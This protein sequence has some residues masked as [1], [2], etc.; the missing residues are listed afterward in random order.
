[1]VALQRGAQ[2]MDDVYA[3]Y[4]SKEQRS[5]DH[6]KRRVKLH[7]A[8]F[9]ANRWIV[10]ITTADVRAYT[11]HRQAEGAALASI[12]NE[13]SVLKRAFKLA[14][15][16]NRVPK[17]PYIPMP[18]TSNARQGFFEADQVRT[19]LA[20]VPAHVRPIIGFAF[21]TGWR[22]PSEVLPLHW[23]Q[24]DLKAGEVRLDPGTTKNNEGRTFVLTSTLRTLL[25]GQLPMH[26][27]MK[28]KGKIVPWVFPDES[29]E[30]F[31]DQWRT[32][33][34]RA[35]EAAGCP[36]RIP[37]DF[38]RT[39]VRNR[40][41]AGVSEGVAMRMT[42]HKTRSVFERYNITSQAD[43]QAA[44]LK[45]ATAI[46]TVIEGSQNAAKSSNSKQRGFAKTLSK[47][48]NSARSATH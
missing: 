29:G 20:H 42:G 32:P 34:T 2:A 24:V 33:F 7:L 5:L 45:Y 10:N 38:R 21:V 30:K 3:D 1:M 16:A 36:G 48:A 46:D 23:R 15:Q 12:R 4:Q 17:L 18:R 26:K 22:T 28:A 44:S 35:C 9:F 25:E 41:R 19:V 8:P 27:A 40:V 37:H 14:Y 13:L 43:L 47:S 11:A 6:T 39:A 31:R